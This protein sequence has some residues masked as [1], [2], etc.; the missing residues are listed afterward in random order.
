MNDAGRARTRTL[1]EYDAVHVC[2]GDS[3]DNEVDVVKA[4]AAGPF[5]GGSIPPAHTRFRY[6]SI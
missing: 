6:W 4:V 3:V 2:R 5:H 1:C